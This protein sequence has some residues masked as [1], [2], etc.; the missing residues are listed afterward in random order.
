[1][2]QGVVM[3]DTVPS[4]RDTPISL[5]PGLFVPRSESGKRVRGMVGEEGWR[6]RRDRGW[7]A[8]VQ[9]C[10]GPRGEKEGY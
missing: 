6:A 9:S 7:N 5:P 8:G 2:K 10:G 3:R 4:F 1:M